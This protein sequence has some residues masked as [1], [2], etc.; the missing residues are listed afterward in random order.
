MGYIKYVIN[1]ELASRDVQNNQ[2]GESYIQDVL[3]LEF[4]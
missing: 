3:N 4:R 2:I 1:N